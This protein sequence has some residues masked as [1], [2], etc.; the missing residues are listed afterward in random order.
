MSL[1]RNKIARWRKTNGPLS[2]EMLNLL[3][4]LSTIQF[5]DMQAHH[6]EKIFFHL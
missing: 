5:Y 6:N 4:N 1:Y 2:V 3:Y